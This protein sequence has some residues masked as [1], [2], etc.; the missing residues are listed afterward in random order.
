MIIDDIIE[1][2]FEEAS[3]LWNTRDRAIRDGVHGLKELGFLDERIDAHLDGLRIAGD[4]GWEVCEKVLTFEDAGEVFAAGLLALELNDGARLEAV[5]A[6]SEDPALAR[7]MISALG[8]AEHAT[9][10]PLIKRLLAAEAPGRRGLG[11]AAAAAHRRHPGKAMAEAIG[12]DDPVLRA[13]ALRT[14]GELGRGELLLAVRAGLSDSDDRCR[15]CAV[16]SVALLSAAADPATT[17]SLQ[18]AA[19]ADPAA[20][21][22]L[23]LGFRDELTWLAARRL[24]PGQ[25]KSWR[26]A[27]MSNPETARTAVVAAGAGGDPA[28]VPWLIEQMARP[29]LARAAG[30]AFAIISGAEPVANRLEGK[31]RDTARPQPVAVNEDDENGGGDVAVEAK[32]PDKAVPWV[33]AGKAAAWW[34]ANGGRFAPGVRHFGG[35]PVSGDWLRDVLRSARQNV[36]SLAAIELAAAHPGQPLFPVRAPAARQRSLLGG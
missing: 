7:G 24:P 35:R 33:D 13:R 21:D 16:R 2:H 6:A 15:A 31:A 3:I 20:F 12:D 17:A 36:R 29:E 9:A 18:R 14:A 25:L 11:V 26:D 23:P 30:A 1:Q 5:L 10:E 22:G 28:S 4:E 27:L 8:W 34:K 19:T 32:D